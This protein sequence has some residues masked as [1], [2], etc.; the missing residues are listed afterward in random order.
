MT[1]SEP[2]VI[3]WFR[4]DL[5][6]DDHAALLQAIQ[7]GRPIVCVYIREPLKGNL[8]IGGAQEW[9]LHHSLEALNKSLN[10][11]GNRLTLASGQASDVLLRIAKETSASCIFFNRHYERD[12]LDL[13]VAS[14]LRAEGL[15]V[16]RFKGQILHNPETMKTGSGGA[17]RVYTPFWRALERDGDPREPV[18]APEAIPAP[19]HFPKSEELPDWHLLPDRP[20]WAEE[21]AELWQPGEAG[22]MKRLESFLEKPVL[23]YK[24][25]RDFPGLGNATS[26]L[27]PHLAFG[28]ISPARIWHATRGLEATEHVIHFRKELVWREFSY[29]LLVAFPKLGE[30][31]WNDRFD[32]FPWTFDE[33]AFEAWTKGKTGYPIVDAGMRQLWRHGYMHNR[34]RM[35]T[36]SFLIKDLMIDWRKGEEW[37]HDTL[38]DADP[39]S[40]AANWQWVA[41]SGADAAPFFRVFNPIL[42]G[43]KFDPDGDY[44][45]RFVPEIANLPTKYIHKPFEAPRE[46]LARAGVTLGK[47]YPN[48]IVNHAQARDRALSAYAEVTGRSGEPDPR[49]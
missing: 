38:L 2:P 11:R 31:N 16:K 17:Y 20:N 43:E 36:G 35:I 8:A 1:S 15:D 39:A 14:S 24:K 34:V 13:D 37:F 32:A 7:T 25:D 41:G 4:R 9:W 28:E 10:E 12:A 29:H 6:M 49:D 42:Q 19:P 40:N 23:T 5:R 3:L 27:S 30:K 45:R 44:V 33:I 22:A 46:V 26:L 48:P 47:T 18:G 21:F